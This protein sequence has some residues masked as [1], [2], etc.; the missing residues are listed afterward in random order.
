[1]PKM[2]KEQGWQIPVSPSRRLLRRLLSVD[3]HMTAGLG[4]VHGLHLQKLLALGGTEADDPLPTRK[5]LF[6]SKPMSWMGKKA[7][8]LIALVLVCSAGR[9]S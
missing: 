4:L 7:N 2:D 1:M 6:Y 3:L 9:A 8:H 5:I